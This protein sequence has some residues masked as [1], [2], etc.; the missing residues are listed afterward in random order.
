MYTDIIFQIIGFASL[1]HVLA[2]FFTELGWTKKPFGCNLCLTSWIAIIPLVVQF[3]WYG[4]L[5][6]YI[7]GVVSELIYKFTRP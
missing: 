7:A 5:A 4:F 6:S 3:G 2:D 1:G